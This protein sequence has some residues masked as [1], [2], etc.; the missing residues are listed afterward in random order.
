MRGLEV[1]PLSFH[2]VE[3]PYPVSRKFKRTKTD[4]FQDRR[5]SASWLSWTL[6]WA[7]ACFPLHLFSWVQNHVSQFSKINTLNIHHGCCALSKHPAPYPVSIHSHSCSQAT[8]GLFS[9][10]TNYFISLRMYKWI[11]SVSSLTSFNL[12]VMRWGIFMVHL[13]LTPFTCM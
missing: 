3:K 6:P 9:I 4:L 1:K 8:V 12:R 11:K 2:V 10:T 5:K 7:S 13:L